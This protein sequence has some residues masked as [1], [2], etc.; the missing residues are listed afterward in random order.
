VAIVAYSVIVAAPSLPV[1][2]AVIVLVAL[3]FAERIATAGPSAPLFVA[4]CIATLVLVGLGLSPFGDTPT[5]FATRVG[6]VGL[7]T[8]YTVG[9]LLLFEP[10]KPRAR[11]DLGAAGGGVF[12]RI[13]SF[14]F[15]RP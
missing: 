12:R 10:A 2:V 8:I 3:V 13:K 11:R 5:A 6:D 9:M 4:A 15:S 1:L 7:A 14:L